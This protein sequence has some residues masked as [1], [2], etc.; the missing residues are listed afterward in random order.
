MDVWNTGIRVSPCRCFLP[1]FNTH[2]RGYFTK[3]WFDKLNVC[4]GESFSK[5]DGRNLRCLC[6]RDGA[7]YTK[8][9]TLRYMFENPNGKI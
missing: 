1:S 7:F 5:R 3:D 2:P 6:L 8:C 4:A 9:A